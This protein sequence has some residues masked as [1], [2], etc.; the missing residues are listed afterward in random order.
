MIKNNNYE[1]KTRVDMLKTIKEGRK[2]Q[3]VFNDLINFGIIYFGM[4]GYFQLDQSPEEIKNSLTEVYD[5]DQINK[6][7]AL[8]K[9]IIDYSKKCPM[10]L[11][12]MY[13]E[14]TGNDDVFRSALSKND[15][16]EKVRKA[17]DSEEAEIFVD[18]CGGAGLSALEYYIALEESD[19]DGEVPVVL[20]NDPCM[21]FAKIA[22]LQL[23]FHHMLATVTCEEQTEKIKKLN[24]DGS[25]LMM[26]PLLSRKTGV[27]L[28][29]KDEMFSFFMNVIGLDLQ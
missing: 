5:E 29:L 26:T 13:H 19:Y 2:I 11:A 6:M 22:Y 28:L 4:Q 8:F 15:I 10:V 24:T 16:Q 21:L 7:K 25:Y 1:I 23:A 9:D 17:I 18:E 12:Y 27:S 20:L 3:K 14:I